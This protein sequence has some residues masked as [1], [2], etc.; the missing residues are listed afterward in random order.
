MKFIVKKFDQL[1]NYEL[2]C[3][4]R[5][6]SEVFVV[7][8]DCVYQDMDNKDLIA[9]HMLGFKDQKIIAYARIFNS[10]DYFSK[11]SI[12]RILVNREE[13]K[14]NYGYLLVKESIHFI[15]EKF[16]ERIIHISAQK[17]LVKFYN[18]LGFIQKGSAYLEDGIPHVA[19]IK[20]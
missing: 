11:P 17:Y 20:S 2:Y 9:Y 15:E 6:R 14:K 10:G 12:G 19:M 1:T 18:S 16:S 4:L 7:E 5:I 8:Q 13:R 3:V